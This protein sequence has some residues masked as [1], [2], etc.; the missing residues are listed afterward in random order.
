G[1]P[2]L[3][4]LLLPQTRSLGPMPTAPIPQGADR[5]AVELRLESDDFPRY[6]VALRD[7]A[8]NTIVWRS[9]WMTSTS[10]DGQPSLRVAFPTAVLRL[11]YYLL[12]L[13][14]HPAVDSPDVIGSYT[15]Q[16]AP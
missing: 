10:S 14:G 16:I 6:Q 3:A 5:I 7:P 1:A 9:G 15:F 11:Q 8:V 2:A 13:R 4:L 12:D